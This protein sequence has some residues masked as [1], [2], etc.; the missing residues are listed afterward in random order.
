[1]IHD[2]PKH[3]LTT[4]L[5]FSHLTTLESTMTKLLIIISCFLSFNQMT[6]ASVSEERFVEQ[7]LDHFNAQSLDTWTMVC[8]NFSPSLND[9]FSYQLQHVFRDIS[10]T[11][12]TTKKV[13]R[14]SFTWA[15]TLLSE[16]IGLN[17]ATCTT[18]LP[19]SMATSLDS[20]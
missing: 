2:N 16:L 20:R 3:S 14:F 10:P 8:M 12:L 1:M 17:M 4:R 6:I 15:A 19:T 9:S 18:S 11:T 13:D 5:R 7:P